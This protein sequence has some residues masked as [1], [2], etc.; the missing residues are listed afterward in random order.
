MM[1]NDDAKECSQHSSRATIDTMKPTRYRTRENEH[2][3][4]EQGWWAEEKT[5]LDA[6]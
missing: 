2:D 3:E 1:H 4:Q 6:I 5:G